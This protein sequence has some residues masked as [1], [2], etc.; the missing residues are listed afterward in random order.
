MHAARRWVAVGIVPFAVA[1]GCKDLA[2]NLVL[3]DAA[4][5]APSDNGGPG[6]PSPAVPCTTKAQCLDAGFSLCDTEAG[7]CA[8]CLTNDDC[9]GSTPHCVSGECVSCTIDAGCT[10]AMTCNTSI[11]RCA[12]KCANG[13]EC[14]GIPCAVDYGYCVECL[15]D[16]DCTT[17]SLSHCLLPPYGLCVACLSDADCDGGICGPTGHCA[18][19]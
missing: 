7:A 9:S 4:P 3:T 14:D 5:P 18:D 17:P 13:T 2:L 12:T 8:N 19:P 1:A 15:S 10:S 11:P 16:L 6:Q